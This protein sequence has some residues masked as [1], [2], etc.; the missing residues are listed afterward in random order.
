MAMMPATTC[1]HLLCMTAPDAYI[2][3][4]INAVQMSQLTLQVYHGQ[5][6]DDKTRTS[7]LTYSTNGGHSFVNL[8]EEGKHVEF[9]REAG[10]TGTVAFDPPLS[11]LVTVRSQ[12][13]GDACGPYVGWRNT[14]ITPVA[15]FWSFHTGFHLGSI[16][17][18]FDVKGQCKIIRCITDTEMHSRN[19]MGSTVV[20]PHPFFT[21]ARPSFV[22]CSHYFHYFCSH[23]LSPIV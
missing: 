11:G 7:K 3:W 15:T 20:T 1:N 17:I 8:N 16:S 5:G 12:I 13:K 6:C 10:H 9:V 14:K 21:Q 18:V 22:K 2:E 4:T 23:F 19:L